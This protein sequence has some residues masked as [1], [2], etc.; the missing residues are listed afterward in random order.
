MSITTQALA[1]A[2]GKWEA[3]EESGE[4]MNGSEEHGPE[5]HTDVVDHS[6]GSD[7]SYLHHRQAPARPSA[8]LACCRALVLLLALSRR[9]AARKRRKSPLASRSPRSL[10]WSIRSF[11]KSCASSANPAS[12]Q[13]YERTSIYPKMTAYIEKWNVDIGDKVQKGDVLADLFVPELREDWRRR[14]RP[15]RSTRSE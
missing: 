7:M 4:E 11:G 13:S 14:R 1:A 12:S 3:I 15:S 10:M 8:S 9:R 2:E 5:R 6:V